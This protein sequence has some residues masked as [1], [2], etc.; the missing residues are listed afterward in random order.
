MEDMYAGQF[1]KTVK[2]FL[3]SSSVSNMHTKHYLLFLITLA[4]QSN[5]NGPYLYG[6]LSEC[7]LLFHGYIVAQFLYKQYAAFKHEYNFN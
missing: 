7:T 4:P 5:I 2:Y 1:I 3:H 6:S